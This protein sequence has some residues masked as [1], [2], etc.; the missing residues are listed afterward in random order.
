[1]AFAL[2]VGVATSAA[3]KRYCNPI[4]LYT[5]MIAVATQYSAKLPSHNAYA[6]IAQP[7]MLIIAP[8]MKPVRRPTLAI[9]RENGSVETAEPST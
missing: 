9:Q 1:M 2:S 3:A 5:P 7:T 6:P 4:A 8:V